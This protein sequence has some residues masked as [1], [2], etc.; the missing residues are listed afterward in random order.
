MPLQTRRAG[1]S[2]QSRDGPETASPFGP[3]PGWY[4]GDLWGSE[5]DPVGAQPHHELGQRRVRG[6]T[7]GRDRT[8]AGGRGERGPVDPD[9][10]I[11][12]GEPELVGAVI[13]VRDEIDQLERVEG[14]EA[15]RDAG[16]DVDRVV[17]AQLAGFDRGDG[18]GPIDQR[19]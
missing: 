3:L 5:S 11:V 10:W 17:G 6:I 12:P 18:P 1:R 4:R 9:V 16:R 15:V 2:T 19:P 7:L 14:E 8:S 13:G